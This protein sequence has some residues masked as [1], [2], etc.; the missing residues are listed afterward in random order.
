LW[1]WSIRKIADGGRPAGN[2]ARGPLPFGD[3]DPLN[4]RYNVAP[5]HEGTEMPDRI[6]VIEDDEATRYCYEHA[7]SR[8]G[9]PTAGYPSYFAAAEAIDH[10]AGRLLVVDLRLPPRTPNGFSIALMARKHRPGLPIIFVTGHPELAGLVDPELGPVLLKPIDPDL[11]VATV[12]R[13]LA[14]LTPSDT[15]SGV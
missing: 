9:Y 10:G 15:A 8:A 5:S 7:L 14:D 13:R 11:L 6:L 4:K 2:N 3:V 12:R 1:W